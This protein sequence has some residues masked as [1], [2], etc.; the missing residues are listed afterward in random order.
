MFLI[1]DIDLEFL[2][3]AKRR[4]FVDVH[5]LALSLIYVRSI[6]V[7]FNKLCINVVVMPTH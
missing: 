2:V 1:S 6:S 7:L 3:S 4:M 5:F